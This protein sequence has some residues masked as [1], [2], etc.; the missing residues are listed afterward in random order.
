MFEQREFVSGLVD[1]V[2]GGGVL[3]GVEP[4]HPRRKSNRPGDA[5]GNT[6]KLKSD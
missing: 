1:V 3:W 2:R 5:E 6:V 4:N